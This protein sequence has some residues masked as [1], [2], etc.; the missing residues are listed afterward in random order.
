MEFHEGLN[1]IVGANN[2]GKTGLLYAINSLNDS[3]I[4]IDDFNKNNLIQFKHLYMEIA[5]SIEITYYI[6][7]L[8]S[9]DDTTDESIIKLVPFLGLKEINETRIQDGDNIKYNVTAVIKSVYSLD[10]KYLEE[11]RKAVSS[12]N[13]YDDYLIVLN[14]F[15]SEHYDW[16]YSNG[17]SDS[18]AASKDARN[19]FDIRFI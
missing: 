7:H 8:I 5:P 10:V 15:V 2:S 16:S 12:L 13:K 18:K 4:T 17:V 11:Y 1:V 14:R 9:I 6:K 3:T 19:I